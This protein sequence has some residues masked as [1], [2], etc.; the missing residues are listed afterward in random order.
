MAAEEAAAE[1]AETTG[2]RERQWQLP[3]AAAAAIKWQ[4]PARAV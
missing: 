3:A 1:A 4:L 2:E